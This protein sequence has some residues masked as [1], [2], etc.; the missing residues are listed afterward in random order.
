MQS[1]TAKRLI[2]YKSVYE[3]FVYYTFLVIDLLIIRSI[4]C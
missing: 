2:I 4:Y 1:K 3:L